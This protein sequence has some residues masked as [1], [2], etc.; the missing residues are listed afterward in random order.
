MKK[1]I[2]CVLLVMVI[3]PVNSFA[4]NLTT[5]EKAIVKFYVNVAG[6][7][8]DMKRDGLTKVQALK[9]W[10]DVIVDNKNTPN[11]FKVTSLQ[12]VVQVINAVY[13]SDIKAPVGIDY[14]TFKKRFLE[15]LEQLMTKSMLED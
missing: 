5:S 4:G 14:K 11:H 13:D 3:V 9:V 12:I 10:T 6:S 1:M 2:V 15:K 7:A 8:M